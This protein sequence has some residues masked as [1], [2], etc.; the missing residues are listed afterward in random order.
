MPL[1]TIPCRLPTQRAA[2]GLYPKRSTAHCLSTFCRLLSSPCD[3]SVLWTV[4][5]EENPAVAVTS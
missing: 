3:A 4:R 1:L 5:S 2:V